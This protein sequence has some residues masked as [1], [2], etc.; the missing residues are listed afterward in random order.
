MLT[1]EE[2]QYWR[3]VRNQERR[4]LAAKVLRFLRKIN[5]VPLWEEIIN[6]VKV[7]STVDLWVFNVVNRYDIT[8]RENRAPGTPA[9]R[10]R[11]RPGVGREMS[12]LLVEL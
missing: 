6:F 3:T 12:N 9:L 10:I 5:H 1:P 8:E 7:G 2:Q 11:K 4:K